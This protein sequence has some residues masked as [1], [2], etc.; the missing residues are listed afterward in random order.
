MY[1]ITFLIITFVYYIIGEMQ[2]ES[3]ISF[4]FENQ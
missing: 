2:K 3:D 4:N 1:E